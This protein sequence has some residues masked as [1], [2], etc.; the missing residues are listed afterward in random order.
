MNNYDLSTTKLTNVY[1]VSNLSYIF[2]S[3]VIGCFNNV[4]TNLK[5]IILTI[6]MVM[7]T[8]SY[9]L[10]APIDLLKGFLFSNITYVVI[11]Y[12]FLGLGAACINIP[13]IPLMN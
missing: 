8:I 4:Y 12:C 10:M 2:A 13:V 5:P 11:G 9:I 6:G 3:I 7:V 1:L